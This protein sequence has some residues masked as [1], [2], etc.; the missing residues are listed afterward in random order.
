M[1]VNQKN[2]I[3]ISANADTGHL[4]TNLICDD[5]YPTQLL[6]NLKYPKNT[7]IDYHSTFYDS[8]HKLYYIWGGYFHS[9]FLIYNPLS[10]QWLSKVDQN[11]P[12]KVQTLMNIKGKTGMYPRMLIDHQNTIHFIGGRENNEHCQFNKTLEKLDLVF[13]FPMKIYGHALI[14]HQQTNRLYLI[15]G[16]EPTNNEYSSSIWMHDLRSKQWSKSKS[17][18]L[19]KGL[20]YFGCVVIES[21]NICLIFGGQT[22]GGNNTD[23]ISILDFSNSTHTQ[24][25]HIKCPNKSMYHALLVPCSKSKQQSFSSLVADVHLFDTEN[26]QHFV[27]NLAHLLSESNHNINTNSNSNSN[28]NSASAEQKSND[29]TSNSNSNPNMNMNINPDTILGLESLNLHQIRTETEC[30]IRV[31]FSVCFIFNF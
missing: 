20:A 31:S 26:K 6:N 16:Y 7:K 12:Q 3:I 19:N 9:T 13:E 4:Q 14:C 11:T 27:L 30:K 28:S 17:M 8:V 1:N 10:E 2:I 15:G 24:L 22:T 21:L 29:N 18:T 5:S 25:T 23:S